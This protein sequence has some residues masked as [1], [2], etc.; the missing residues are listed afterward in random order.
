MSELL[1]SGEELK[2]LRDMD[3]SGLLCVIGRF[4]MSLFFNFAFM[5]GSDWWW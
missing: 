2:G 3:E 5:F 4:C 1:I